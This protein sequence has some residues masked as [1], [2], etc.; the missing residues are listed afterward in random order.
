[1]PHAESMCLADPRTNPNLSA[2]MG[3]GRR[4]TPAAASTRA[5]S[6]LAAH[7]C[8]SPNASGVWTDEKAYLGGP[9]GKRAVALLHSAPVVAVHPP[10]PTHK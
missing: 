1:M 9:D 2:T 7:D 3:G 5:H 4:P 6:L 10:K 8:A